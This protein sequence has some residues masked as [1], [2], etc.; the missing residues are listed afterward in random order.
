M[1][2]SRINCMTDALKP[3]FPG[4]GRT[5]FLTARKEM[6]DAFDRP[7]PE[8][9]NAKKTELRSSPSH[10]IAPTWFTLCKQGVTGSIPVSPPT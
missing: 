9:L 8:T 5:Q 2:P 6:L 1:T 3:Q 4:Q 7:W 10:S